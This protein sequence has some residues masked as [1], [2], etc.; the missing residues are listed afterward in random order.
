MI[1]PHWV[2]LF[3]VKPD[4]W[5]F[6]PDENTVLR[7]REIKSI[8][9]S[10]WKPPYY[11]AH[12]KEG[13]HVAALK[14]HLGNNL[15]IRA[16]IKQFF[17]QI[18]RSKVTR[19]VNSL[20]KN[21]DLAREVSCESTVP[22]PGSEP[23]LIVLPFGFV[24]SPILASLCLY[25]S[26]LGR[27]INGLEGKGFKV[28]VY[29]DDIIISTSL[30]Y[31]EAQSMLETLKQ[32]AIRSKLELNLE[33]TVGP[34]DQITAFNINLSKN[35]LEITDQKLTDFESRLLNTQNDY[36]INGI[37]GYVKTVNPKQMVNLLK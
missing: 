17:N 14:R 34:V 16:D 1:K 23:K 32:K 19:S 21:Y 6:V 5:V 35:R 28:S 13:G 20:L 11:Y 36:V 26:A 24:Q 37:L 8:I 27:F 12:F 30:P 10:L 18:N 25:K 33:K 9:S 22:K 4:C 2:H 29:M 3:E 31:D 15:F 7:G